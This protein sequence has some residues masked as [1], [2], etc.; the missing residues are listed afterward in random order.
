M[1]RIH[2][3]QLFVLLINRGTRWLLRGRVTR[4]SF[5]EE[6]RF[7]FPKISVS[8]RMKSPNHILFTG[9]QLNF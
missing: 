7:I 5:V 2:A 6:M 9:L 8:L 3:I 4:L 1:G